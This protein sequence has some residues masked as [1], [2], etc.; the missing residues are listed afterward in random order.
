MKKPS[1]LLT[2]SIFTISLAFIMFAA[3][4][5][6]VQT[7]ANSG[8]LN[9]QFDHSDIAYSSKQCDDQ[10][11]PGPCSAFMSLRLSDGDLVVGI[12]RA[13]NGSITAPILLNS[14]VREGKD[15]NDKTIRWSEYSVENETPYVHYQ[16]M[17]RP[18]FIA[19]RHDHV[20]L[21]EAI[22]QYL[23]ALQELG[24]NT[25]VT[26]GVS[27]NFVHLYPQGQ[28]EGTEIT[29]YR[30]DGGVTARFQTSR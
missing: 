21:S 3:A 29:L 25:V 24:F 26:P 20:T 9:L 28:T 2:S 13:S 30:N 5:A 17:R 1:G 11:K 27:S 8:G 22:D 19:L 16:A 18:S 7:V 15:R 10:A 12:H 4:L 14:T 23:S 6:Q